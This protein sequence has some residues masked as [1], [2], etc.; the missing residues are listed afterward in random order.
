MCIRDSYMGAEQGR[1]WVAQISGQE[2]ARI[3]VVPEWVNI[4]DF[5]TR[6]PSALT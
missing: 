1:A 2:M 3:R 4:L 6:L 5:E